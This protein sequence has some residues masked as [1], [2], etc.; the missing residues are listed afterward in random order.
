MNGQD[1]NDVPPWLRKQPPTQVP[2]RQQQ[3]WN[4]QQ[5]PP[6]QYPQQMPP[7]MQQQR[8]MM[9]QQSRAP[10]PMPGQKSPMTE[11]MKKILR[12]LLVGVGVTLTVL[13]ATAV[14]YYLQYVK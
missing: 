14:Y 11:K 13:I 9:P 1:Q 2:Q 6:Q 12:F 10:P 8:S 3:N 4:P 5:Y 7:Q